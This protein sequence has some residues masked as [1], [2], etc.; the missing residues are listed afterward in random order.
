M[1]K[2]YGISDK[3]RVVAEKLAEIKKKHEEALLHKNRK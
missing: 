3:G 1:M 2:L